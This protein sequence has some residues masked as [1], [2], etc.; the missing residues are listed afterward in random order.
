MKG[1]QKVKI[2]LENQNQKP[3]TIEID[4]NLRPGLKE[5][6]TDLKRSYQLVSFTAS[7]RL[8]ADAIL[9]NIDPN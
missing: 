4:I 1:E 2:H 5:C 3:E 8:Y 6:L 7:D 9:D